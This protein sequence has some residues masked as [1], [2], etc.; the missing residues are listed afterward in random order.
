VSLTDSPEKGAQ[1]F[2]YLFE[3]TSLGIAVEDLEG[4]LL[5][6]NPALCSMLGYR[7]EE[8]CA[9][10]CS[11]FANPEDAHD[12][13]ALFQKLRVGLIDRYPLEK[14]YV[15][16][17][18]AQ[19]WG[20]LNVSLL[21]T[22][23]GEVPLVFA[24][25]EEITKR[26]LAEQALSGVSHKLIEAQEHERARIGR[27]LHDDI[28]QRLSLLAVQLQQMKQAPPDSAAEVSFRMD[29]LWKQ[30]SEIA[31]DVQALS[32]DL[33]SS[34]LEYMGVV[35]AM[36]GFCKEFAEQQT[37]EIEFRSH[38]VPSPLPSSEISLSLFRVLQEAISNA[39]KH[40]GVRHFEV[41]LWGRPG[42]VHLT[43]SDS[44]AGFHTQAA[45]EGRGLGLT[46]MQ[47]RLKLVNGELA[48]ES[49]PTR[50]TTIH[51]RVP[52]SSDSN[53]AG[54]GI[55]RNKWGRT[56]GAFGGSHDI[57]C[58]SARGRL[59]RQFYGEPSADGFWVEL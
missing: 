14:R 58:N 35:A 46:S 40:S 32:H 19:I 4:R 13:W 56:A 3:E 8:L 7:E 45:K 49:Q 54:G 2:R 57:S 16:K 22:S 1:L 52:L 15:R 37:V 10:S 38:D 30:A 25:V 47:E 53:S 26:K 23:D 41:Q 5:L 42:E 17:D 28:G 18:G 27:D 12:D 33:H 34:K 24:F 31:H 6:A 21:K 44:G 9:M 50:G 20:R 36:R 11:E 51:A 55:R 39:A 43:I 29:E 59:N 48:I